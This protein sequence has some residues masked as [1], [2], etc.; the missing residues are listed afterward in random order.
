L[1]ISNATIPPMAMNAA[2]RKNFSQENI[3]AW[4][5]DGMK[6]PIEQKYTGETLVLPDVTDHQLQ[7]Q[8]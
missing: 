2:L 4:F 7:F 1:E 8:L 5:N 3:S 6:P